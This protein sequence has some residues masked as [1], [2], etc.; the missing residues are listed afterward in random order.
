VC[1]DGGVGGG[2]EGRW[3]SE[4]VG[5][6]FV[7]GERKGKRTRNTCVWEEYSDHSCEQRISP[8][9]RE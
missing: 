2:V 8:E 7:C 3:E 4:V 6:R 5:C 9:K 1:G